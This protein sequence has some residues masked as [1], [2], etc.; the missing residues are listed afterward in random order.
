MI[1]PSDQ[2]NK[3]LFF[4]KIFGGTLLTIAIPIALYYRAERKASKSQT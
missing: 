2:P 3:W 1:P 4:I